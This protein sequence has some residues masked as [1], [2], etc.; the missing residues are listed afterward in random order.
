MREG[1]HPVVAEV[2]AHQ[3]RSLRWIYGIMA[4]LLAAIV[5][6]A[7][8]IGP[9]MGA[10]HGRRWWIEAG[11]AALAACLLAVVLPL[12]RRRLLRPERVL[13]AG[14]Q[15]LTGWGLPEDIDLR[16]GRQAVY[17]TR[18]SAGCVLSWGLAAAVAL[19]GLV[20]L[21]L[22]TSMYFAGA[23][24]AAATFVLVL[25]P[26]ERRRLDA[27]MLSIARADLTSDLR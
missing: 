12:S 7:V 24:F 26:P 9:P 4:A 13:R 19:Y 25:L 14:R 1:L 6:V 17:L 3:L 11:L 20:A 16:L 23:Y 22:G 2:L 5:L 27:A 21:M 15:Q 18:Y 8:L 10:E